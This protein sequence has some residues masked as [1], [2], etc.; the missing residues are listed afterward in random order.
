MVDVP[1]A[2]AAAQNLI[3]A[4]SRY[5]IPLPCGHDRILFLQGDE[6]T[7]VYLLWSGRAALSMTSIYGKD[8]LRMNVGPGTILG[9]PGA[10][11]D[12]PYS[13]TAVAESGAEVGFIASHRFNAIISADPSLSF[14]VLQLLATEVQN[15][16]RAVV[17]NGHID[18]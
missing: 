13:L 16:R 6:P 12:K 15:A 7:G 9:L 10:I 11:S 17:G 3:D 1:S 4:L 8:V 18:S 14:K 2:P 5:A